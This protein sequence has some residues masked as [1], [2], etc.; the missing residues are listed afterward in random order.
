MNSHLTF[1]SLPLPLP[2]KTNC[3]THFKTLLRKN[4]ERKITQYLAHLFEFIPWNL[5]DWQWLHAALERWPQP[6]S[7]SWQP[8]VGG[9]FLT[10]A[11]R[12]Q[13]KLHHES[14]V[15][16]DCSHRIQAHSGRSRPLWGSLPAGFQIYQRS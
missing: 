5:S 15:R 9:C 8:C 4:L 10:Q 13:A 14:A 1:R 7:C 2:I 16:P 3:Y 12:H 11:Q 6:G